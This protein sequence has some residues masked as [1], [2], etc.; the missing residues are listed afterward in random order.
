[1]SRSHNWA[2]GFCPAR[3]MRS[4]SP[5]HV[6]SHSQTPNHNQLRTRQVVRARK[7]AAGGS[8]GQPYAAI[9][10]TRGL[11]SRLTEKSV[12]PC[13]RENVFWN[14]RGAIG[15]WQRTKVT[16]YER[17]GNSPAVPLRAAQGRAHSPG[18]LPP[19]PGLPHKPDRPLMPTPK[20]RL[21][22]AFD[23]F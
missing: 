10:R 6:S 15:P 3:S 8:W 12:L 16:T 17:S 22:M 20:I 5:T 2:S 1:M 11:S 21:P 13:A 9:C 7:V 4:Y 23:G 14:S 18:W 19:N